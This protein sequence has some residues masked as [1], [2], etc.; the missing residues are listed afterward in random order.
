MYIQTVGNLLGGAYQETPS[1][2]HALPSILGQC[3]S[4]IYCNISARIRSTLHL[5]TATSLRSNSTQSRDV[6]PRRSVTTSE[7]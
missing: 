6:T 7:I 4:L 3:T 1:P 5:P 2:G